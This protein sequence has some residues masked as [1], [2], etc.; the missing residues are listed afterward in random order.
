MQL[1]GL[2]LPM[3]LLQSGGKLDIKDGKVGTGPA[4]TD[5]DILTMDYTGTLA[6]GKVFDSSKGPGKKPFV[7]VLGAG[8]VIKG[9]DEGIKGMKVGGKR[10]LVIP[11]D[12]A[13]GA[14][15][16]PGGPIPANATLKFEV[17][18]KGVHKCDF[19][20]IKAGT[21]PGASPKD[22]VQVNLIGTVQ[23]GKE[24]ANTYTKKQPATIPLNRV[25]PSGLA[26]AFLGMKAGEKRKVTIK[27]EFGLGERS[28]PQIPANS[29]LVFE[30]ELVKFVK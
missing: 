9:W 26:Q 30:I 22:T 6:D 29:T 7:F 28:T 24:F 17:E 13:Y 3:M 4:A 14:A 2:L 15:G 8:Q 19:T 11:P 25:Q 27:P 1:V 10:T 20:V 18:L 23:G 12:L 21:G 16:T 5:Y